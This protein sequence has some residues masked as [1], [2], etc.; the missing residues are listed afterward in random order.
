[1]HMS[2]PIETTSRLTEKRKQNRRL[3]VEVVCTRDSTDHY[4]GLL[5]VHVMF[6]AIFPAVEHCLDRLVVS[7]LL[8]TWTE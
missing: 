4:K 2:L 6:T 1:M 5:Y 3:Q 7:T 8:I